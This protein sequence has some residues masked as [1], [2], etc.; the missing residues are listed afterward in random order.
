MVGA[1]AWCNTC[2]ARHYLSQL[3]EEGTPYVCKGCINIRKQLPANEAW[4]R[5]MSRVRSLGDTDD[6]L[7]V[8]SYIL[9]ETHQHWTW[10][11]K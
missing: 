8:L 10:R 3:P 11:G 9:H 6:I 1:Y 4:E 7:T 5:L 2:G